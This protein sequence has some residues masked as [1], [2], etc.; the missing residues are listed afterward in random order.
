MARTE[1]RA[2]GLWRRQAHRNPCAYLAGITLAGL[3]LNAVLHIRWIDPGA[4]GAERS[5]AAHRQE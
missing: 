5:S 2:F 3:V 4:A 1:P